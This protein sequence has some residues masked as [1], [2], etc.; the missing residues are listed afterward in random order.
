MPRKWRASAMVTPTPSPKPPAPSLKP[1]APSPKPKA[2]SPKPQAPSPQPP[3]PRCMYPTGETP[4]EILLEQIA[5]SASDATPS[6]DADEAAEASPPSTPRLSSVRRLGAAAQ[7]VWKMKTSSRP[8]SA[9][10]PSSSF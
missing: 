1:Q 7:K 9:R 10:D 4:L 8:A 3:A 2:P 6:D 5:C